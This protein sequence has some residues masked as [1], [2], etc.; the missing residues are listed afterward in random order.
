MIKQLLSHLQ[1]PNYA[2]RVGFK[3]KDEENDESISMEFSPKDFS[4]AISFKDCMKDGKLQVSPFTQYLYC[5]S[6]IGALTTSFDVGMNQYRLYGLGLF[7]YHMMQHNNM[8]VIFQ[9]FSKKKMFDSFDVSVPSFSIHVASHNNNYAPLGS[10]D[11]PAQL[12]EIYKGAS[13]KLKNVILV[14]EM[15]E[16]CNITLKL[17]LKHIEIQSISEGL[18]F[19]MTKNIAL[20]S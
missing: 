11:I 17:G 5:T 6:I 8:N 3:D 7:T 13:A 12:I 2:V 15:I 14:H 19:I 18:T 9:T 20:C 10:V 1:L 16:W 4:I